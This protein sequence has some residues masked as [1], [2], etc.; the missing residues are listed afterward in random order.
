MAGPRLSIRIDLASGGRLQAVRRVLHGHGV[1]RVDTQ[2]ARG[3]EIYVRRR[4]ARGHLLTGDGD[5]EAVGDSRLLE[6]GV[7][8]R[9][10][11]RD[12]GVAGSASYGAPTL[13]DMAEA[14]KKFP[15]YLWRRMCSTYRM[16]IARP[17]QFPSGFL[18]A[19][20]S[21]RRT[22]ER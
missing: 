14:L 16:P 1:A 12:E 18:V 6:H 19:A 13:E 7:A 21:Q 4:L 9:H 22:R 11:V 10:L 20:Y 3:G 2:P 17:K 8:E 5:G 15:R